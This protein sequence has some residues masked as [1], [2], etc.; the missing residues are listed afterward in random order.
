MKSFNKILLALLML[1]GIFLTACD[2]FD[3]YYDDDPPSVPRNVYTV[4]GDNRVDIFW[5]ASYDDDV[6]GYNIFRNYSATGDFRL[7]GSTS[8][9]YFVDYSANNGVTYYYAIEAYDYNGNVSDLSYDIVYDTPRPEGFNQAVFDYNRAP[10]NA[11]YSFKNYLVVPYDSDAADFFFENYNGTYYINVWDD[12]DLQD[13]GR[14]NDIWE[15]SYAPVDGWVP[16]KEGENVKYTEAIVGHTYVVWTWDNHFAKIRVKSISGDRM[17]FDWAYQLVEGN[18]ELKIK[19]PN[20]ER[21]AHQALL[22]T[23]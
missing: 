18:P 14:T 1:A 17:V 9:T 11:G 12:S 6:A 21:K 7:I 20:G 3:D 23:N 2:E 19:Q 13:M 15:I 22:K 16:L 10:N 4:T 5:D 8:D